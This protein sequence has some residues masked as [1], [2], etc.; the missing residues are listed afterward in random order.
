MADNR[1]HPNH[2]KNG[3]GLESFFGLDGPR[4]L[5]VFGEAYWQAFRDRG[6]RHRNV[7]RWLNDLGWGIRES[8][9]RDYLAPER[10]G[11]H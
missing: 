9:L 8:A 5:S 4:K 6:P 3:F 1:Y 7:A 10:E 11:M 2:S